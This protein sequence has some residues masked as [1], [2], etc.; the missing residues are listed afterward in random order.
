MHVAINSRSFQNVDSNLV[1]CDRDPDS[2]LLTSSQYVNDT[3]TN[4]ELYRKFSLAGG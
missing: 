1:I 4:R 3:L 2:T